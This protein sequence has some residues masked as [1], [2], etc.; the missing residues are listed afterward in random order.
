M[1]AG[2]DSLQNVLV[3]LAGV[4]AAPTPSPKRFSDV[5][6]RLGPPERDEVL[7]VVGAFGSYPPD[8]DVL[9]DLA[10]GYSLVVLVLVGA[11]WFAI[12]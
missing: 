5:V 4:A 9:E 11:A 6:G 3:A 8:P 10:R 7:V 1:S 12:A 2:R